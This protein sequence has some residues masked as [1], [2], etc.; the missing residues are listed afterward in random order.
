MRLALIAFMTTAENAVWVSARLGSETP[1]YSACLRDKA[2]T[3]SERW[4]FYYS[5]CCLSKNRVLLAESW[6]LV[7]T[8]KNQSIFLVQKEEEKRKEKKKTK[9]KPV[10]S[11]RHLPTKLRFNQ[12]TM[13]Q[14]PCSKQNWGRSSLNNF[15]TTIPTL[16]MSELHTLWIV[17]ALRW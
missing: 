11:F 17:G 3:L 9:K 16:R 6:R 8:Y 2:V 4:W 12:L 14:S 15:D 1:R 10:E 7:S 13:S 5:F